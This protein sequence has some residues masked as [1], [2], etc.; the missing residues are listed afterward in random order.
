VYGEQGRVCIYKGSTLSMIAR[1]V[2]REQ[3]VYYACTTADTILEGERPGDRFGYLV[4]SMGTLDADPR[5]RREQFLVGAIEAR[6]RQQALAYEVRGS[7]YAKLY[8][9][10]GDVGAVVERQRF[11][12]HGSGDDHVNLF[13]HAAVAVPDLTG[14]GVPEIV[15]GAPR[16][17]SPS[18][19]TMGAVYIF[20]GAAPENLLGGPLQPDPATDVLG[21]DAHF[22]WSLASL[23][24]IEV[25]ADA[26]PAIAIGAPGQ[27]LPLSLE[28]VCDEQG[29]VTAGGL[30]AGEIVVVSAAS[31]TAGGPLDVLARYKGDDAPGQSLKDP[32]PR[33]GWS[34]A[35]ID[36][37]EDG[38]T[39]VIGGA[40]GAS[41]AHPAF[42]DGYIS[43]CGKLVVFLSRWASPR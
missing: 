6:E 7:G 21:A 19:P 5:S 22:G 23:G 29:G 12:V 25:G 2:A 43:E 8:A 38:L 33:L 3:V 4:R 36:L 16:Y 13:G 39:D 41:L 37:D 17:G 10:R 42:Q 35:A 34:L 9:W 40:M 15:I 14:D 1:T 28:G 26:I 31:V 20:D 11:R 24:D 18:A 30:A 32:R 27:N